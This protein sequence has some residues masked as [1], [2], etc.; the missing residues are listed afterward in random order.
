MLLQADR[1]QKKKKK[2]KTH[3]RTY[4]YYI[5]FENRIEVDL[6]TLNQW[7]PFHMDS[8]CMIDEISTNFRCGIIHVELMSKH[9]RCDHWI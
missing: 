3:G 6:F 1:H 9:R 8:P 4:R 5:D 7:H 2:K